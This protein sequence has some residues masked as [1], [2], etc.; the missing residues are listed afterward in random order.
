MNSQSSE[1]FIFK[2]CKTKVNSNYV[3]T[4]CFSLFHKSCVLR[5]K[6]KFS[7]LNDNKIICCKDDSDASDYNDETSFLEKTINDLSDE[8]QMQN[9]Y[10]LKLKKK[11]ELLIQEATEMETDFNNQILKQQKLIDALEGQIKILKTMTKTVNKTVSTK[12]CQTDKIST[13]SQFTSTN[14]VILQT[15][16]GVVKENVTN[17][18]VNNAGTTTILQPSNNTLRN[19]N[20]Y[21][22][23]V[24][25]PMK[26]KNKILLLS[27]DF[28]KYIRPKLH[29]LLFEYNVMSIVKPSANMNNIIENIDLLTSDFGHHDYVLL[30]AGK[31]D[32]YNYKFPS[33]RFINKKLKICSN[34]NIIIFSVPYTKNRNLNQRI[35]KYNCKLNAYI[36]NLNKITDGSILYYEMNKENYSINNSVI[37]NDLHNLITSKHSLKKSLIFIKRNESPAPRQ[38]QI[39]Q[40]KDIVIEVDDGNSSVADNE[41]ILEDTCDIDTLGNTFLATLTQ[42][43]HQT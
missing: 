10:I 16:S 2:C 23:K 20:Q 33:F 1:V 21:D 32:L 14:N 42:E 27:D 9:N 30:I 36:Q 4:K 3:C 29:N 11:N 41:V 34:T 24:N 39:Q 40:S 26:S 38:M 8:N 19:D 28:G 12:S 5:N 35:Y 6:E 31:N 13:K 37:C 25:L 17:N 18:I 7:F 15:A 43:A 22:K